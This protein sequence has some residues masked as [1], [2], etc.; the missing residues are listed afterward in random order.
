MAETKRVIYYDQLSGNQPTNGDVIFVDNP[1]TGTH[2]MDLKSFV[3]AINNGFDSSIKSSGVSVSA[4]NY[5]SIITNVNDQPVN[6]VYTYGAGLQSKVSNLPSNKAMTIINFAQK[7]TGGLGQVMLAVE[8]NGSGDYLY[9]RTIGGSPAVWSSWVKVANNSDVEAVREA[10][11][12]L[13]VETDKTLSISGKPADAKAAGDE[14]NDLKADL[15]NPERLSDAIVVGNLYN[16]G[17]SVS[18]Y[19]LNVSNGNTQVNAAYGVSDYIDVIGGVHYYSYRVARY[20]FYDANKAYISGSSSILNTNAPSNAVFLRVDFRI[21]MV[22][23]VVVYCSVYNMSLNLPRFSVHYPWLKKN[24]VNIDDINGAVYLN[25]FNKDNAE[26]GFYV[27]PTTGTRETGAS[28]FSTGFMPAKPNTSYTVSV[29]NHY[30]CYDENRQYIGGGRLSGNNKAFT[31][32]ANTAYVITCGTPISSVETFMISETKYFTGE[33]KPY[34]I[35]IPWVAKEKVTPFDIEGGVFLN[36]FDKTTAIDGYYVES[37]NGAFSANAAYW[38]SQYISVKPNTAYRQSGNNRVA[39]YDK[40]KVYIEGHNST[41]TFTS[42]ANAAYIVVCNTPLTT[43]DTY[44]FSESA[45]YDTIYHQ[46]GVQIPWLIENNPASK[47][48]GKRLVC[49]GDSITNYGYTGV[50]KEDT[51]I[52][53]INVGLSS[54]RYAYSDDS[55]QYVNAF[56]FHNIC[57]SIS[58]GDWTIPDTLNGVSGYET[59]YAHIQDIK[60]IDFSTVDFASIAYGT[61]DFAS[62]TVLDNADNPLD[63]N[64]FKGAIRYCLKLLTEK[65]PHLKIIGVTPCYRF[66]SKNGTILYDSDDHAVNG[67]YMKQYVDAVN[68]VYTEYHL[69]VVNNYDNAG[70]NKYNCLQYFGINDGLHPNVNGRAIIGHRIG[71]G[72]LANY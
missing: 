48:A 70:I 22:D 2:K 62:A 24:K 64:M 45:N 3:D 29:G 44:I 39:F 16:F 56:A 50:I 26:I 20:V 72:I 46:Y 15:T 25:M 61:N 23:E 18:G 67:M 68:E 11:D 51:G 13:D 14:I 60:A 12:N 33:Y 1:T 71:N 41:Y 5:S 4:D 32:P 66:W 52:D 42:P 34:S 55:N 17:T 40:D 10:L 49:F 8:R 19:N 38:R 58:T 36:M 28:Y 35:L 21:E 63:T 53:A 59:Q 30:A 31:T 47:Y 65:Y 43:K 6:S 69:P 7:S 9:F 37:T 57:Y 54:G 27:N